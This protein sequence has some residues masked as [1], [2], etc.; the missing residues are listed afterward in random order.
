MTNTDC[1]TAALG[2]ES[3][4]AS[5]SLADLDEF[6]QFDELYREFPEAYAGMPA[7]GTAAPGCEGPMQT[8]PRAAVPHSELKAAASDLRTGA[9]V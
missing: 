3:G 6:E 2:C 4:A 5:G 1:G 8:Q 7:C 9:A